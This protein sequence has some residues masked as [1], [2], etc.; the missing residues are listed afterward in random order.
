[1]TSACS[2]T[3]RASPVALIPAAVLRFNSS[4]AEGSTSRYRQR[5]TAAQAAFLLL[6]HDEIE[7]RE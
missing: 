6:T 2:A 7:I 4:R 1:M 3:G 5:A